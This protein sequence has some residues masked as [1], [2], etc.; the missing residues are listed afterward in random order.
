[1]WGA[2]VLHCPYCHGWE[3]RDRRLG[4]L[5]TSPRSLHQAQL[6][7]QWSADVTL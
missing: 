7:R 3:V 6:V 4:V 1:R 2:G 5:A